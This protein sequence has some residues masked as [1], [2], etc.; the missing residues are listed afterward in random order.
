[1]VLYN[2]AAAALPAAVRAATDFMAPPPAF[3]S[4]PNFVAK[5]RQPCGWKTKEM[6]IG[7]RKKERERGATS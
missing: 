4:A 2:P 1:M 3:A 5:A 7:K 6:K